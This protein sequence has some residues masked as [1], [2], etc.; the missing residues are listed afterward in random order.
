MEEQQK[1]VNNAR[2]NAGQG[3]GI[4]GLV[5]GLLAL[6]LAFIPC[7]GVVAIG[8]GAIAIVLSVV[9]LIQANQGNGAKGLIIAALVVSILATSIAA[10]WGIV[11]G[12]ISR[13]T[14][15]FT[16][17]VERVVERT[18]R[19]DLRRLEESF[20]HLGAELERTFG[21]MEDFDPEVYE[22]GEE[23]SDEEFEKVITEYEEVVKELADLVRQAEHDRPRDLILYSQVSVRA[24][25]LA[26]TL[27]RVG[28]RLTEEQKQRFEEIHKKYEEVMDEAEI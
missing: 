21:D 24:A 2:T 12:G 6:I 14:K 4:A 27:I 23:I 7:V 18:E 11:I 28:P 13:D 1:V 8:P 15:R 10:I 22:F 9:G 19:E 16:E 17:R 25:S 3:F 20:R 26:A 5:V